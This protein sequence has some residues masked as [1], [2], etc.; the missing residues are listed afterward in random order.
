MPRIRARLTQ[1]M[2]FNLLH[3]EKWVGDHRFLHG[4]IGEKDVLMEASFQNNFF[5]IDLTN[6]TIPHGVPTADNG[7]PRLY[8][9]MSFFNS[10]GE[11]V[12]QA[13]E[14]LAPQQETALTFN[15]KVN[16]SYRLFD[17]VASVHIVL[18]YQPAWSKDKKVILEK[19]FQK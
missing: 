18:K 14:I 16:F 11:Q 4:R 15:K 2:G 7:D 13:K 9:Y 19:T 12:D 6:K 5:R 8:L 10:E 17:P 3:K 1:K